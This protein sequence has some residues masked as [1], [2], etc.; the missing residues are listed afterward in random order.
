MGPAL[1]QLVEHLTVV[2]NEFGSTFLRWIWLHLSKVDMWV[3]KCRWFES[4]K[5]EINKYFIQF[6]NTY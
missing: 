3:S 2:V 6:I 4:G 5:P 1:A